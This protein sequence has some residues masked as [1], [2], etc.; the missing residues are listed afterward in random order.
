MYYHNLLVTYRISWNMLLESYMD[1][2]TFNM[3]HINFILDYVYD[4]VLPVPDIK[5]SASISTPIDTSIDECKY[6]QMFK[7]L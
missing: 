4:T 2:S 5:P 1:L 3:V 7:Q 6:S